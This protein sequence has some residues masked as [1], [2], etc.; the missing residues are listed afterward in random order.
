MSLENVKAKVLEDAKTRAAAELE[1]AKAEAARILADGKAAD[2][3][4]SAEATRDARL[5]LERET[6][7]ELERLGHDNRLQIL[8]AKNHAVDQVFKRTMQK[9]RDM[10]DSEYIGLIG[11]WLDELPEKAG[12]KLRVNPADEAK[13]TSSLAQLNRNRS[14]D[15]IFTGV[16]ADPSVKGGAVVEGPD[17]SIDCTIHRRLSELRETSVGDLARVLFGA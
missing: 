7:R 1:K 5:R 13:F 3:R 2:E 4:N 16:V 8:H 17:F 14:G 11:K 12:G 10:S 9:L 15:G 6:V